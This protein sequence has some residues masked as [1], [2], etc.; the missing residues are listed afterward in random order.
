MNWGQ[1]YASEWRVFRV[2]RDTWADAEQVTNVDSVS[3]TRTA[4][5][6]LLESGGVTVTGDFEPD[7]YRIVM[8]AVQG[9]DVARVDVATLLFDTSGGSYNRRVSIPD[10]EGY[11]VLYPASTTTVIDGEYAPAGADGAAYAGKLL[12][13][14]INAPV[15]IEGS[16]TLNEHVVHEI[17]SKVLEAVWAVLN[18]GNFTIQIDGRGVVHI[19]PIPTE[20]A[21]VL[22]TNELH[23]LTNGINYSTDVSNVPNRYVVIAGSNKTVAVNDDPESIV[24]TVNRGYFVDMVDESPVPVNGE[25][26]SAYAKRRLLESS[27]MK[28][29]RSY[30]REYAPDVFLG[31]IIRASIDGLQ[32]DLRVISQTVSCG[33]GVTISEKAVREVPLWQTII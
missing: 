25:T 2:N 27:C 15:S 9:A 4:D 24:S 13:E 29:E 3:I 12:S 33:K 1:S 26:L 23:L 21:L 30:T 11:S 6:Q 16:F 14:T 19:R 17:G 5:G 7:Y 20:P 32:G 10:M 28:D 18:A 22:S 8:T 31:S